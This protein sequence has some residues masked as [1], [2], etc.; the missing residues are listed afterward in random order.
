MKKPSWENAPPWAKY[1]AQ[2]DDGQWFWYELKPSISLTMGY[3]FAESGGE[4]EEVEYASDWEDSLEKR[5]E[6]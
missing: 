3:F 1:L 6:L 4:Y 5:G 2:N